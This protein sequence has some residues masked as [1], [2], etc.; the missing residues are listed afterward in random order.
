MKLFYLIFSIF[1]LSCSSNDS[2]NIEELPSKSNIT[3]DGKEFKP[4]KVRVTKGAYNKENEL[5]LVFSLEKGESG[6]PNYESLVFRIDYPKTSSVAPNGIYEFGMGAT[7]E[8]LFANGT[9][10]NNLEYL[11]LAG[12]PVK[13]IFMGADKY[14]IEFQNVQA[15]DGLQVPSQN[16][17]ITIITGKYEGI[18]TSY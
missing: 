3:I 18:V 11:V 8:H 7:G 9:Y 16:P 13:I 4:T 5:S 17:K 12:Y 1:F 2:T 6:F 14:I 15:V 10:T